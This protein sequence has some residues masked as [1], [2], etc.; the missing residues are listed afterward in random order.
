MPVPTPPDPTRPPDAAPELSV[1]VLGYRSGESLRGFAA[2]VVE[3]LSGFDASWEI[4]MVA[5]FWPGSGDATPEVA[6]SL[7]ADDPRLR[8]VA[9][10]K[11]GG[12][13]WDMRSGFDAARGR[14]V[15]VIDG[16]GQM[17]GRDVVRVFDAVRESGADLGKTYRVR[18]DDGVLRKV[19]ST[20]YNAVF[21]VLFPGLRA[22]DV[23]S[24]PKLLRREVLERM[25]LES[26]DWFVDAE[27]LIAA[28]RLDLA[29][30]EVPTEFARL[31]TRPSF[32]R[33]GA[34][35]EFLRNLA[36]YRL[37]EWRR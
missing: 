21:R 28:R 29:I 11:R 36:R 6:R 9:A 19:L 5:N 1:V 15:A 33:L 17:P 37:R 16:D 32:V 8:T 23:N 7:A 13:G 22:H 12:M 24:K 2:T 4:V 3:A 18:R 34:V 26:D 30:V 20:G 14:F 27:I 10:A 31:D 25:A 35:L